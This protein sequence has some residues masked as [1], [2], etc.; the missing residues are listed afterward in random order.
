VRRDAEVAHA[1]V[2]RQ[3]DGERWGLAPRAS[4]LVQQM[5]DGSG[6]DGAAGQRGGQ[7]GVERAGP[8]LIEQ[9]QERR[10]L[11]RQRLAAQGEGLEEGRRLRAALAEAIAPRR[12]CARRFS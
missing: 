4:A 10:G 8:V 2:V 9:A 3:D 12:S 6:I 5:G 11:R 7:R 1:G